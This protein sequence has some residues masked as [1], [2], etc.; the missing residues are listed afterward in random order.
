MIEQLCSSIGVLC[1]SSADGR[2]LVIG[3]PNYKQAI[4]YLFR[5]L[6]RH[7]STVNDLQLRESVADR[8]ALLEVHGT[9][10]GDEA[11]YGDSV[12][13]YIGIAKDGPNA[14]GTGR[15]FLRPK[16]LVLSQSGLRSN[17]EA[18]RAADREKLRRDFQRRVLTV[19]APLH[20]QVLAGGAPTL[21]APNTL[22]RVIDDELE[23]DETWLIYACGYRGSRTTKTTRLML[24]PQGTRFV[25]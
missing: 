5:H 1:W 23:L 10:T 15:D 19:E 11:D 18:T 4:Q 24:V 25:A 12:T 2:E 6:N 13:S 9:S 17:A 3:E 8:Y 7:G 22:A 14:D 21:F 20:G 16:R